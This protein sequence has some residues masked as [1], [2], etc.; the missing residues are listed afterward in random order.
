[1]KTLLPITT[2][3]TLA[4]AVNLSP[5]MAQAPNPPGLGVRNTRGA[6]RLGPV[7][8]ARH[9]RRL[10]LRPQRVSAR[11]LAFADRVF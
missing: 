6:G 3:L 11:Q 8:I 10:G 2:A 4:G 9:P 1:M 7:R 5:A